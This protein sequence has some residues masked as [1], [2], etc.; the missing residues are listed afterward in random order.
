[1]EI[2]PE[3]LSIREARDGLSRLVADFNDGETKVRV[4]GA[5]RRPQAVLMSADVLQGLLQSLEDLED[6]VAVMGDR[7][8]GESM[9]MSV[10]E[11]GLAVGLSADEVGALGQDT[12]SFEVVGNCLDGAE[13]GV[14]SSR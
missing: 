2:V 14:A 6:L 4:I 8:G 7:D 10:E 3:V 9:P 11:L 1:M 5:H 13:L 12:E